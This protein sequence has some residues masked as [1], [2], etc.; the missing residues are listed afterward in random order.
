MIA[1]LLWLWLTNLSLLFGAELDAELERGRELQSGIAA[2][3]TIQ[4]PRATP[5]RS[6]RPSKERLAAVRRGRALR[7]RHHRHHR[8]TSRGVTPR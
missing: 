7:V 5:A 1:F 3:E 4:L 6:T 2:E 8:P